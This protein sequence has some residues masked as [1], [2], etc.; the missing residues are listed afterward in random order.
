MLW[1]EKHII[2][3]K[4]QNIQVLLL[5]P[6]GQFIISNPEGDVQ[7]EHMLYTKQHSQIR[8]Q[9]SKAEVPK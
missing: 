1:H 8:M 6:D 4:C 3:I 2:W 7:R 5:I 9:K